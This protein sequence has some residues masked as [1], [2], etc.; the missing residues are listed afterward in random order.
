MNT[1]TLHFQQ[2]FYTFFWYF[3]YLKFFL[4]LLD[5]YGQGKNNKLKKVVTREGQTVSKASMQ[6]RPCH[7]NIL[8]RQ[9]QENT[10]IKLE[11]I[12]A[13]DAERREIAPTATTC[14][15]ILS[16]SP[17]AGYCRWRTSPIVGLIQIVMWRCE[18]LELAIKACNFEHH[19]DDFLVPLC[20]QQRLDNQI[21]QKMQLH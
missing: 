20:S 21:L 5:M 2:F 11:F 3:V 10:P 6:W 18:V 7:V 9:R 8:S 12:S 13:S 15:S 14:K 19:S 1:L 16:A 4:T 17:S